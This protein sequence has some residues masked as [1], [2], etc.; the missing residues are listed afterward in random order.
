MDPFVGQISLVSFGYAPKGWAL[1][2][3]QALSIAQNQ[4]LFS[5][6]GTTFG[7][8]GISTF[9]LPD[10]RGRAAMHVGQSAWGAA[11]GQEMVTLTSNQMATHTHLFVNAVDKLADANNPPGTLW[12]LLPAT[13]GF[14]YTNPSKIDGSM[15]PNALNSAGSGQPHANMQPSLVVNF[16]IALQGLYPSKN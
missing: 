13:A 16:I 1:C 4:P 14:G 5:I 6:I 8:D 2:N 10:L 9:N 15:A 11:G 7:G 12:G 3:G